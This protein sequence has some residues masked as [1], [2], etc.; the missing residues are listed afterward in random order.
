M[1]LSD[2]LENVVD[3]RKPPKTQ[4]RTYGADGYKTILSN[5][6]SGKPASGQNVKPSIR[7]MKRYSS[8]VIRKALLDIGFPEHELPTFNVATELNAEHP[9]VHASP[10][11]YQLDDN[12]EFANMDQKMKYRVRDQ[13]QNRIIAGL[14]L[15]FGEWAD[16]VTE[17]GNIMLSD[18]FIKAAGISANRR[19][20]LTGAVQKIF[21][22]HDMGG[23][24]FPYVDKTKYGYRVK[25]EGMEIVDNNSLKRVELDLKELFGDQ[26]VKFTNDGEISSLGHRP[27]GP[28]LTNYR[29]F[30]GPDIKK[31]YMLR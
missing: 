13:I 7:M 4:Q 9:R 16:S 19:V 12:P 6:N 22:K 1:K 26:F 11:M 27:V 21:K 23:L 8:D 2:I 25:L 24:G 10:F 17:R 28:G 29:I 31:K 30:L 3:F 18:K 15:I 14:A 20:S 5:I